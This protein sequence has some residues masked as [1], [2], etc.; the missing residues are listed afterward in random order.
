MNHLYQKG[1]NQRLIIVLHGTGGQADSLF[2]LAQSL[3]KEASL[4]GFQGE[5]ME[6]GM[7]R[8][9]ARDALGRFDLDSL[10][11]AS[12]DLSQS[13]DRFFTQHPQYQLGQTSIIGYSNGANLIQNQLKQ[14][15]LGMQAVILFHP[16][17]FREKQAF[18]PQKQSRVFLSFGEEDPYIDRRSFEKLVE[19]M[20]QASIET[21]VV[22]DLHGH[23][24]S[25][26]E[27]QAAQDFY[28]KLFSK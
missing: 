12:D 21:E 24:L 14:Q 6:G 28:D 23:G 16:S 2:P 15:D 22:D 18:H 7:A 3:D 13:L 25:L 5:V 20:H 19:A 11:Q 8:Y 17:L 1:S 4:L 9:F 10:D 26:K 27:I